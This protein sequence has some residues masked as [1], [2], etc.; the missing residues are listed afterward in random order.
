MCATVLAT[1]HVQYVA[2]IP[3]VILPCD[4]HV[5][6]IVVYLLTATPDSQKSDFHKSITDL[7]VEISAGSNNS[8]SVHIPTYV[9][10]HR[11]CIQYNKVI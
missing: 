11:Y 3:T 9:C 10:T 8:K 5:L 4:L 6:R 2:I 1:K 7:D